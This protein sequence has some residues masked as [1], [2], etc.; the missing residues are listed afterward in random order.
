VTRNDL[1]HELRWRV[2]EEGR[3]REKLETLSKA[4]L[5]AWAEEHCVAALIDAD[6]RKALCR[7][8]GRRRQD[9]LRRDPLVC[10]VQQAVDC[11]ALPTMRRPGS[12]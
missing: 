2:P 6:E 3:R 10:L 8:L 4:K 12:S 7:M 9:Y 5:I 1:L 11:G